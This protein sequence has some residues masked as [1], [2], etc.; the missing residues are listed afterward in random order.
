MRGGATTCSVHQTLT[1]EAASVLKQSLGLARRRGHAQVTPL[2]VAFTLLS[3]R[4]S[5]LLRRAC[6]KS[7]RQLQGSHPLQCRALE[8][9]FNVA[10]NRLPTITAS[11]PSGPFLHAQQP[12]LSN[13]LVAALKRAQAHQRRGCIEQQQQQQQNQPLLA[14]KVELEQLVLSILDDPS[15]SRVMREAGFS[16]TA[17]KTNIEDSLS[18]S[19][20]F[21]LPSINGSCGV[22]SSPPSPTREAHHHHQLTSFWPPHFFN[23][24]HEQNPLF[25]SL[26]PQ[27]KHSSP[28]DHH[29][30]SYRHSSSSVKEDVKLVME[31]MLRKKRSNTMIVGDSLST[32]EGLVMELKERLGRGEVPPELKPVSFIKF[33]LQVEALKFMKRDDVEI[34]YLSDVR[35]KVEQSLGAIIYVGDL[36]WAVHDDETIS[37][38][39][40]HLVKEIGKLIS[41][42][43]HGISGSPSS[44]RVWVLGTASFQTYMK[45]QMKFQP[46]LD[47][48]WGLQAVSVP[49]GGLGL[50]LHGPSL[51]EPRNPF[52]NKSPSSAKE[53]QL[54]DKQ[55]INCCGECTSNYEKEAGLCKSAAHKLLP[56]WLQPLGTDQHH[57]EEL[58]E[59]RKKWS[60]LCQTLHQGK[61][62]T[63]NNWENA[64]FYVTSN[65]ISPVSTKPYSYWCSGPNASLFPENNSISFTN[66]T[67]KPASSIPRFR[68]QNSCTIEFDI[69]SRRNDVPQ[70][71]LEPNLSS[72]RKTEGREVKI[73]LALGNDSDSLERTIRRGEM[74]RVIKDYIPWQSENVPGIVEALM[75]SGSMKK[76]T[77]LLIQGNDRIGKIRLASAIGESVFGSPHSVLHLN[78]RARNSK[79]THPFDQVLVRAMGSLQN[80]VVLVEDVEYADSRFMKLLI[81][82]F[83]AGKSTESGNQESSGGQLLFMLTKGDPTGYEAGENNPKS[84]IQMVLKVNE[85][86]YAASPDNKRKA[87]E[88]FLNKIKSPRISEKL[89][90]P[91]LGKKDFSR[92]SSFNSLDLNIRAEDQEP[93]EIEA[94]PED[95]SPISSDLTRE[96][97]GEIQSPRELLES[98]ENQ[99][100]FNR[101]PARDREMREFVASRIKGSFDEVINNKVK[102]GKVSL[103]IEHRVLE[104][105][106]GGGGDSFIHNVFEKWLRD[107]F[108]TCLEREKINWGD[109]ISVRLCLESEPKQDG[110]FGESY[111]FMSTNLPK[112]VFVS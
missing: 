87:E 12:S 5:D 103:G 36:K 88:D 108:Q 41:D 80:L 90:S 50:S 4:A 6:L 62:M 68:R 32:T 92:Q 72:L 45:C 93:L 64:T 18:S 29:H 66:S 2:H 25:S 75:D 98:I 20:V 83:E 73:T 63:Q 104:E 42:N 54:A 49:S 69:N 26:S 38:A 105:V 15:V 21:Q 7:Q 112:K 40:D 110:D 84:V 53:E 97:T 33:Q 74:C 91:F 101:S 77:W 48:Q 3:S 35:R 1:S 58:V 95:L 82:R 96:N 79:G 52:Q 9:C 94:K 47:L 57:E 19:P 65:Q 24:S 31:V 81:D 106:L 44:P 22:F 71:V 8:L 70:L 39:V 17:V 102:G 43:D 99:F 23:H 60:R 111:G 30:H 59:L 37:V 109:G 11:P 34:K 16:S 78:M 28:T 27:Q 10:L 14:A 86:G 61:H 76:E 51:N 13:A 100:T 56:S 107:I 46:P 67:S 85:R 55:L 89:E